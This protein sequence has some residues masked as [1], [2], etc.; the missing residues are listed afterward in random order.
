MPG[1]CLNDIPNLSI[2]AFPKISAALGPQY[3]QPRKVDH[4][5]LEGYKRVCVSDAPYPAIIPSPT[6]SV[7]GSL[8]FIPNT[9]F[10]TALDDF[11]SDMYARVTVT[12][13]VKES[14]GDRALEADVYIWNRST[15]LL[16]I[17]SDWDYEGFVK[18]QLPEW[19]KS[20]DFRS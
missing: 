3:N 7:T 18:H 11:E 8:Y 6:A 20:E 5:R 13:T 17:D 16:S 9:A 19:I 12:V 10:I 15:D 14:W 2:H 1:S 4:V